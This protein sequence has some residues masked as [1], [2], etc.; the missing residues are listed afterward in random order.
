MI[1]T[2]NVKRFSYL[3]AKVVSAE[4]AECKIFAKRPA[5]GLI[6]LES[7]ET[8]DSLSDMVC[9]HTTRTFPW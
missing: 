8:F 3:H 7:R 4:W 5:K 6:L 9:A 1:L 2:G